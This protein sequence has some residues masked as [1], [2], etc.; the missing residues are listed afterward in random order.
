MFFEE[1]RL[2]LVREMILADTRSQRE[3]ALSKIFPMQKED[4]VS[5]FREMKGYP[6][7]VRL[8]DPPLHEFLPK[9]EDEIVH[10]ARLLNT[11]R[12]A[13]NA[14]IRSLHEF[15]PMLGHRG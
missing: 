10:V 3:A 12:E 8:L 11:S 5:I 7:T 15:N 6:V 14:K 4:F 9:S 2:I 1:S 13:L